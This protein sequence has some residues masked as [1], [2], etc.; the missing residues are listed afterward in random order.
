MCADSEGYVF[1]LVFNDCACCCQQMFFFE[2]LQ[3]LID[4]VIYLWLQKMSFIRK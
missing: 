3:I 2:S 1:I 4:H